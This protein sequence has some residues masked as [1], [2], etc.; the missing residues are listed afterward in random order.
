MD[1]KYTQA[2]KVVFGVFQPLNGLYLVFAQNSVCLLYFAAILKSADNFSE[3]CFE[4]FID[5]GARTCRSLKIVK[6]FGQSPNSGVSLINNSL[7]SVYLVSTNNKGNV[8]YR[9]TVSFKLLFY[10]SYPIF[11]AFKALFVG[12]V[13]H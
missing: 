13:K 7:S 2:L 3:K 1:F 8:L 12:D 6:A 10:F 9:F 4:H 11:Q 5:A